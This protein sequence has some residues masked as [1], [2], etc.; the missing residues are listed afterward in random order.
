MRMSNS[1]LTHAS[2]RIVLCRVGHLDAIVLAVCTYCQDSDVL[3]LVIEKVG[4]A[5]ARLLEETRT[6][7]ETGNEWSWNSYIKQLVRTLL[8]ELGHD[9]VQEG[10]FGLAIYIPTLGTVI[11]VGEQELTRQATQLAVA[12]AHRLTNL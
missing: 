5:H 6:R 1:D 7:I 9:I 12:H 10:K 3:D 2:S 11:T 8:V 4:N